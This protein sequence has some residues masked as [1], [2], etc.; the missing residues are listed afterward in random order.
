MNTSK[1][2]LGSLFFIVSGAWLFAV[3]AH[4][5]V[6]LFQRATHSRSPDPLRHFPFPPHYFE[7]FSWETWWPV[8]LGFVGVFIGAVFII[9]GAPLREDVERIEIRKDRH[10]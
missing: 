5:L 7:R 4:P 3:Q 2:I 9:A 6:L 8:V 1:R 10:L